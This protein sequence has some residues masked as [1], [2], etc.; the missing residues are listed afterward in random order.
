MKFS[1]IIPVYNVEKYI[2]KCVRSCLMQ[3]I[4]A[5]EYEIILI[6]DGSPDNSL[7]IVESL[8]AEFSNIIIHSQDNAGLSAARNKGLSQAKGKYIW[9]I[10][11]DDWIEENCLDE[12]YEQMEKF[13]LDVLVFNAYETDGFQ[14]R[15]R[16]DEKKIKTEK[17]IEGKNY[18][19][20]FNNSFTVWNNIFRRDFLIDNNLY[21]IKNIYHEDNE[22]T[23][24]MFYFARKVM[25]Y[26]KSLYYVYQN[27]ASITRS[28]N[29]KKA[30]DLLQVANLHKVFCNTIVNEK[31]I[32]IVFY[33]CIGLAINSALSNTKHMTIEDKRLFYKEL[34]KHREIFKA[35]LC[36]H[37]VKYRSEALLYLIS[38][39][40][41]QTTYQLVM[42]K[43]SNEESQRN[44]LV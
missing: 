33:N 40:V 31:K 3:D 1:L 38:P 17:V 23:P 37:K 36:S 42:P 18:L 28:V 30:F 21:F 29:P 15:N 44:I 32:K 7:S 4:P 25:I 8:G 10:D 22:F 12:L 20:L 34:R 26:G 35:M 39:F 9:F 16:F 24:R 11:S 27:P 5:S 13:S 14:L 2:E 41:F 6:N 43:R 19:Y